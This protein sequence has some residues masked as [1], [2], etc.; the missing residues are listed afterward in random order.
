MDIKPADNAQLNSNSKPSD[1][2]S[3]DFTQQKIDVKKQFNASILESTIKLSSTNS[4]L[5]LTLKSTLESINDELRESLG[6]NAIQTS[7]DAGIDISPEATAE[8]IVSLSTAQFGSY[9]KQHPEYTQQDAFD[10]FNALIQS[11]IEKGFNEAKGILSSLA[12]LK[13]DIL[14]NINI[15]YDLVQEKL[16]SFMENF[17]LDQLSIN[18]DK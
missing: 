13:G 3:L 5:S 10:N 17:K 12:V 18:Q 9:S 6:D 1:A 14:G 7:F 2:G 11:G 4:P 8:R 15:T 16:G